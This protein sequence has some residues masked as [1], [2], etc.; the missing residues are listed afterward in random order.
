MVT[1]ITAQYRHVVVCSGLYPQ[2]L[3]GGYSS[4]C[5]E[6]AMQPWRKAVERLCIMSCKM[7][8]HVILSYPPGMV[9]GRNIILRC[10]VRLAQGSTCLCKQTL[11]KRKLYQL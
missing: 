2:S 6:S 10:N 1:Y 7:T 8:G 4:G 3:H 11:H 5:I 9:L